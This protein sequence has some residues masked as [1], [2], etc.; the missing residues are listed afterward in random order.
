[1]K[2]FAN[3]E[4]RIINMYIDLFPSYKPDKN[5]NVNE[6][7]QKG[8]YNFIQSLL[9]KLYENP[10]LLFS[11][12]NSDDYFTIRFNKRSEN[13]QT[14]YNTMRKIVKSIEDFLTFL[15]DIGKNVN[16]ENNEFVINNDYKIPK[17]YINILGN[18][19]I[20]YFQNNNK[21][22]FS[23]NKNNGI[24]YCWKWFST[25]QDVTLPHFIGCM[26]DSNYSYTSEIYS[27]LSGN[28]EAFIKLESFL[29]ENNY[30]R[31]DNRNKKITLDYIK[32]YD[33]KDNIIKEAWAERTH[34]GISVEYDCLM[35][36]PVLFS[37]RIPYYKI[38][39]QHFEQM[40]NQ[41]INFIVNSGKKCDN[42]R[43]C[44]Q[45]DKSGKKELAYIKVNNDEE[46]KICPYFPGFYYCWEHLDQNIV[47]NII[48]LLKFANKILT[49]DRIKK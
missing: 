12:I 1:M 45:T 34:G 42:C 37:L 13:K 40:N 20:S 17:R 4:Q 3:M 2:Q 11:K 31:I 24:F 38:L 18:C 23:Q 48:G 30:Y 25:K 8:F 26:F 43:Y 41:E 49:K 33:P 46:Y 6:E 19:G 9:K 32:N 35:I 5:C 27:K 7:D 44:V 14:S 21:H 47:D 16:L 29:H 15:F 36:N 10:L 22:Y 28:E 39:L